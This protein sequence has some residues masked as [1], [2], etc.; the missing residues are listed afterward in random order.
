MKRDVNIPLMVPGPVAAMR[1]EHQMAGF[2]MSGSV[3]RR[4]G[5]APKGR[6][7]IAQGKALGR[8]GVDLAQKAQRAATRLYPATGD[9]PLGLGALP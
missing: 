7:S 2:D 3:K 9:A 8:T 6:N 1:A 4:G 5:P